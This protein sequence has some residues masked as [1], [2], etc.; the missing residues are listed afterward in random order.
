MKLLAQVCIF[1]LYF[2]GRSVADTIEL[3]ATG[4][5]TSSG[6]A[7]VPVGT[8]LTAFLFYNP[9]TAPS[10]QTANTANYVAPQAEVFEFGGSSLTAPP[11]T[12]GWDIFDF[13]NNPTPSL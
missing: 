12:V 1:S 10:F 2:T 4:S 7:S 11:Q 3:E 5:V 8:P 6:F 9:A 13:V